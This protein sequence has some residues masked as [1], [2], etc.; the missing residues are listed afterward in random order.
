VVG[1]RRGEWRPGMGG[2]ARIL[3]GE[4]PVLWILTHRTVRFLREYFWL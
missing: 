4:R 1:D 3:I 2:N